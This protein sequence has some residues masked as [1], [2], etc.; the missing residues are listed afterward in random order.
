MSSTE[1]KLN[2]GFAF[3]IQSQR[4][5]FKV[6]WQRT[7]KYIFG[8]HCIIMHLCTYLRVGIL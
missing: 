5:Y 4:T 8:I 2:V 6:K 3:L 7:G 1:I